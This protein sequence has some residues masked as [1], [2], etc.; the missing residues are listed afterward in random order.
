MSLPPSDFAASFLAHVVPSLRVLVNSHALLLELDDEAF[1]EAFGAVMAEAIRQGAAHLPDE[2]FSALDDWIGSAL[3]D[4]A[5]EARERIEPQR[6]R[7]ARIHQENEAY[8]AG[9]TEAVCG[10]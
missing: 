8:F 6:A 2:H 7:I 9:W 1:D 4:A 3:L 10:R 5:A